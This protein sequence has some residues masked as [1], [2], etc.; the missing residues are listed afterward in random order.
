MK[1]NERP[2]HNEKGKMLYDL[3][4]YG[5]Q[6]TLRCIHISGIDRLLKGTLCQLY[7]CDD[8]LDI[9]TLKGKAQNISFTPS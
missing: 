1:K 2:K 4:A 5:A 9:V 6:A 3:E 7:A 8:R